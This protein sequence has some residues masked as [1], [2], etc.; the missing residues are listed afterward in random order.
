MKTKWDYTSLANAYLERPNYAPEVLEILFDTAGLNE[1]DRVCDVGAGVAHL[2]IPL[3]FKGYIVDA[4][5]PNDAMRENGIKRTAE[6]P[7]VQWYEGTGENTGRESNTYDFVSFGS[8]F[9]VCD[10]ELAMKEVNRILKS[11]KWF[12]CMW[13][14]RQ[15]DNPI[16]QKIEN[17]I[18]RYISGYNYGTRREDQTEIISNSGLFQNVQEITGTIIHNQEIEKTVEAWRSHATLHR[19]AGESFDKIIMDIEKYLQSLNQPI[20]EIPYTTRSWIAQKKS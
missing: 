12:T 1:G 20:I 13:N 7:N 4:V 9:N 8:S 11:D 2:T 10:R 5:E 17:I 16:Q 14:H 15:L 18:K 6:L 3:A 19:Q